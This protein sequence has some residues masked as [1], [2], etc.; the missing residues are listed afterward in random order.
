MAT[1]IIQMGPWRGEHHQWKVDAA[2][3]QAALDIA[4]T[5]HLGFNSY[6]EA[7]GYTSLVAG[8]MN[9]WN[10]DRPYWDGFLAALAQRRGPVPR[11]VIVRNDGNVKTTYR[12]ALRADSYNRKGNFQGFTTVEAEWDVGT[13]TLGSK[14]A[15]INF[16]SVLLVPFGS[17]RISAELWAT[18]PYRSVVM[19][20]REVTLNTEDF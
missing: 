15:P 5:A 18:N 14:G 20:A 8:G 2:T 7:I 16:P 10:Q 19:D 12:I 11:H 4:A 3:G 17:V 13:G 6:N 1:Y 9:Q